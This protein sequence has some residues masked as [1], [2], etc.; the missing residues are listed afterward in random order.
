MNGPLHIVLAIA[1]A[2]LAGALYAGLAGLLKA[3]VGAHEVITTIM[4]NW[5]AVWVGSWLFGQGGALQSH[6]DGGS[7]PM[8]N[9]VAGRAHLH[10]F[11]GS[12]VAA[13]ARR[14]LLLRARRPRRLCGRC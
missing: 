8:S 9:P 4:L 7:I 10:V 5:I 2:T 12:P 6:G 1:A 14:R 11:W 13:G 3:I